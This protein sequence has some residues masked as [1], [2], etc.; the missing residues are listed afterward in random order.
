MPVPAPERRAAYA[1]STMRGCKLVNEDEL[2]ILA[3]C[4]MNGNFEVISHEPP[5]ELI[6]T[7]NAIPCLP[8]REDALS[9]FYDINTL[10]GSYT[11][12]P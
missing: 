5:K 9:I 12:S 6:D 7:F 2:E 11:P 1:G 10:L 8:A 4:I 3:K